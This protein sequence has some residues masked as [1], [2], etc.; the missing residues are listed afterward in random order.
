MTG[1]R[2]VLLIA[3]EPRARATVARA[4]APA[5]HRLLEAAGVE[6]AEAA[7]SRASVDVVV[8]DVPSGGRELGDLVHVLR[9]RVPDLSVVALTDAGSQAQAVEALRHGVHATVERGAEPD[10]LQA[11]VARAAERHALVREVSR[12][13]REVAA[14]RD[15]VPLLGRSTRMR[16]MNHQVDML[17]AKNVPV[18]ITGAPGTGKNL[19]ARELHARSSRATGPFVSVSCLRIAEKLLESQLFGHRR[20]AFQ[21]ATH[22]HEGALHL[23]AGGTLYLDRVEMLSRHLQEALVHVLASA[24]ATPMGSTQPREVDVRLVCASNRN[25]DTM[26]REGTFRDDLH[27][28][29]S[30]A[31]LELPSLRDRTEDVLFL[32]EAFVAEAAER[33]GVAPRRFDPE[34]QKALLAHG[35][36]GNVRE[37]HEAV[38]HAFAMAP[39]E[40]IELQH[41]PVAVRAGARAN[42]FRDPERLPTLAEAEAEL[43]AHVL[44][45]CGGNKTK[46]AKRLGIDRKRLYRKIR[47]Y[48]LL[49]GEP[50]DE[51]DDVGDED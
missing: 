23:A 50:V 31:R 32:A 37:L 44:E 27:R 15:R 7:L 43:V 10:V 19:V 21:G 3:G 36:P 47:R 14:P 38:Q 25:L 45:E 29:V 34:A 6:E 13:R 20:G 5:G 35:W 49:G 11:A 9:E 26:V 40:V 16:E 2:W 46:A 17:A 30:G 1:Q 51:G 42:L 28:R 41:L 24:A 22:D 39:G 4:L 48:G 18:L 33:F 12:L 8:T